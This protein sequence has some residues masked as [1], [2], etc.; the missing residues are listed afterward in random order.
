MDWKRLLACFVIAAPAHAAQLGIY[1]FTGAAGNEATFPVDAQPAHATFSSMSRGTGTTPATAA[2]ALNASGWTTGASYDP[3]DYYEF[4][5]TPEGGYSLTLT[6]LAFAERRSATGIRSWSVRSSADAYASNIATGAVPDDT[7]TR[8]AS[9]ALGAS[10]SAVGAV[11]FRLYGYAAE[12]AGG[13]WRIDDVA[14]HGSIDSAGPPPTNVQFT[15]ASA[16]VGED[17]VSCTVTVYKTVGAGDV[18]GQFVLSGSATPGG[19]ADYTVSATNFTLH[20]ATTSATAVVT[21]NDDVEPETSETIVLTLANVSGGTVASPSAFTLT[22]N[23]NDGGGAPTNVYFTAASATVGEGAGSYQ[24]AVR[25]SLP[26]GNVSGQ[27]GLGGTATAGGGNDYTVNATNF[28]LNGATTSATLVITINDDASVES[29]ETVVLTLTG[30][31]GGSAISPFV[32][33][34]SITNNDA[35]PPPS[36]N[37]WI[38]ELHYDNQGGDENEGFEVAGPAG[39][40]LGAFSLQIYNGSVPPAGS[41]YTSI[42]M[43]GTIDNE[44]NGYGAVWFGFGTNLNVLR[45]GPDGVALVYNGSEVIQFLSYEGSFNATQG[46][47]SGMAS[48][49]IGVRENGST[50]GTNVATVL[51]WSLQVCGTGTNYASFA[52]STNLPHSRGALNVCQ[53]I[54]APSG[55]GGDADADGLPDNWEAAYFGNTTNEPSGDVDGDGFSNGQEFTAYTHPA[56][57]NSF[58]RATGMTNAA[59]PFVV[60]PSVTGRQY[61]LIGS[62]LSDPQAWTNVVTGPV[63]GTGGALALPVG[64]QPVASVRLSVELP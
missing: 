64:T 44:S 8:N 61:R 48:T 41:I 10:F 9:V 62:A 35:A 22:V 45:N 43:T 51:D 27:I 53:T 21:L 13:T 17:S 24:L 50:S 52:W 26:S 11:T 47:A 59:G 37:V 1:T 46:A 4:T 57:S 28:T 40:D 18:S 49:D 20:G 56:D 42:V 54:P 55:G 60:L 29:T 36:L 15:G 16:T 25:K 2:D 31:S 7:N 34:L 39:T 5:L 12:A 23:D 30:V 14:L 3:D 58:F 63:A 6:N 32:F 38:N 19:G 33:T